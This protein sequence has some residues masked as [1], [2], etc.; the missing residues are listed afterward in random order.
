MLQCAQGL[1]QVPRHLVH[2]AAVLSQRDLAAG[3]VKQHRLVVLLQLLD[4]PADRALGQVQLAGG[5]GEAVGISHPDQRL[6]S[7]Q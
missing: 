6:Q 1:E 4:L 5:F 3:A 2:L 7:L